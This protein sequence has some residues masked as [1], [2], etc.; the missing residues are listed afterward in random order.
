MPPADGLLIANAGGEAP[1]QSGRTERSTHGCLVGRCP[2]LRSRERHIRALLVPAAF[3]A[4][5]RKWYA[6]FG[7]RPVL[8]AADTVTGLDPYLGSTEHGTLDP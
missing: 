2:P 7:A 6:V 5:I 8:S 3:V 1:K 4:E